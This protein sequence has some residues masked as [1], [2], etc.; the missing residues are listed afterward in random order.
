MRFFDSDGVQ[1]AYDVVG[2]GPPILLAHGF[3]A[4]FEVNWRMP[5]WFDTLSARGRQVIGFDCRGHG[6]SGKPHEL[7]RYTNG[8]MQRDVV[9]LLDHLKL[10]RVDLMGYSMGA[11]LLL[12][13]LA[14]HAPR[15]NSAV[16]GGAGAPLPETT[17]L[18]SAITAVFEGK[19]PPASVTADELKSAYG[20]R[21]FALAVG[22]DLT[23]LSCVLRSGV[24]RGDALRDVDNCSVPVLLV[25][26][27]ND[28][29]AGDPQ[30]LADV[31][32]G[33]RLV[34]AVGCDHIS[35]VSSQFFRDAVLS[36]LE[37]HGL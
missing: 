33:S 16:L 18:H 23:A 4:G 26:G 19:E 9:R 22:N 13:M 29:L 8:E 27:D 28:D 15:V 37:E 1:I 17:T 5:G 32:P 11:W 31:I 6:A 14:K 24:L 7:H 10:E 30:A 25:A 20:F 36:F 35:T 2:E 12:P 21:D 34:R 3:A